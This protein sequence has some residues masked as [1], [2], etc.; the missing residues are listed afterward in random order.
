MPVSEIQSLPPF[1]CRLLDRYTKGTKFSLIEGIK[2]NVEFT[3][4]RLTVRLQHRAAERA[5][6]SNLRSVLF[7]DVNPSSRQKLEL[8]RL[9]LAPPE[10]HLLDYAKSLRCGSPKILHPNPKS[11]LLINL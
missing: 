6:P 4:N 2:F 5:A 1:Y 9:W 3:I 10:N 11:G 7:P 8:P